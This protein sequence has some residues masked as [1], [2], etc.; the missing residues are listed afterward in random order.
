MSHQRIFDIRSE[1]SHHTFSIRRSHQ[2]LDRKKL[3]SALFHGI[4]IRDKMTCNGRSNLEDHI[5]SLSARKTVAQRDLTSFD[6]LLGRTRSSKMHT[7]NVA[8][9]TLVAARTDLYRNSA[10]RSAKIHVVVSLTNSV[11]EAGGRF[12]S[13]RDKAWVEVGRSYAREKVGNSIR[14]GIK[15]MN[16]GKSPLSVAT[17]KG[18]FNQTSSFG[19]IVDLLVGDKEG[20]TNEKSSPDNQTSSS[21]FHTKS[22]VAIP[23]FS[24]PYVDTTTA[25][26][27]PIE[28][29]SPERQDQQ[30][31]TEKVQRA[32]PRLVQPVPSQDCVVEPKGEARSTLG[33]AKTNTASVLSVLL[34]E[35][36]S[37]PETI[38]LDDC[39]SILTLHYGL[40]GS[41]DFD[42][43]SSFADWIVNQEGDSMDFTDDKELFAEV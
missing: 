19:E 9:R 40:D 18:V 17:S 37:A 20:N 4:I 35:F 5:L 34:K 32:T 25:L 14:D 16:K 24:G 10:S 36:E 30:V 13:P 7:G 3:P 39:S 11:Y 8:L 23:S 38:D 41:Y 21:C 43:D 33:T 6:V 1:A 28:I 2:Y 27:G 31:P 42:E 15:R 22:M 29:V 26:M 12:L